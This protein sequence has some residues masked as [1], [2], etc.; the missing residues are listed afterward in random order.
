MSPADWAGSTVTGGRSRLMT[1]LVLMV[2]GGLML[3]DGVWALA[4]PRS[5]AEF[6]G[7]PY[8]EHFLHD[9]GAFQVGIGM[10]LLLAAA[11]TD[12]AAVTLA[13][14][15]VA[16]TV[17]TVNH[18]VDLGMGGHSRDAWALGLIS[19]VTLA[20]LV[21]RMRQLG[22]VAGEITTT[23]AVAALAPFVRQKT[24]LLTSYRR[25]G[26]P[27]SAPVS[28][29]VDGDRAYVRSPGNGGKIKRIRRN[30]TVDIAPCTAL[31]RPTGPAVRMRAQL[32]QG[33][34]FRYAGRLLACKYPM[35][36]GAL[37]PLTHRLGRAKFGRTVHLRLTPADVQPTGGV[38][39]AERNLRVAR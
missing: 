39:R 37:V 3:A 34:E 18:I 38:A 10:M 24:V 9:A 20:A 31:G 35:L 12:A 8:S 30:P 14:F 5:F 22:W 2:T 11:W 15:L 6:V 7:F 25:D 36:Q 1:R 28:I 33:P 4:A 13:G 21:G 27:V 29:A 26:T 19:V 23:A 16:N 17:H 32:L